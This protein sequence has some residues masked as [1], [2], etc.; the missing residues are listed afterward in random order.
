MQLPTLDLYLQASSFGNITGHDIIASTVEGDSELTTLQTH[1]KTLNMSIKQFLDHARKPIGITATRKE[2]TQGPCLQVF[3]CG[4]FKP[5]HR[6]RFFTCFD[7]FPKQNAFL[8]EITQ[9]LLG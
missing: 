7:S 8:F 2:M 4:A 6:F 3:L 1:F 5:C 9:H